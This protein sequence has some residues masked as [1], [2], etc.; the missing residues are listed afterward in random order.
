MVIFPGLYLILVVNAFDTIGE[1]LKKLF[2][3]QTDHF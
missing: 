3:P 1:S 2:Y